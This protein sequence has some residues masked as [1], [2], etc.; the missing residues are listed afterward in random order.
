MTSTPQGSQHG[1]DAGGEVTPNDPQQTPTKCKSPDV[2]PEVSFKPE[3]KSK[4]DGKG[5]SGGKNADRTKP[6]TG[7]SAATRKSAEA[8]KQGAK[9]VEEEV[10][11]VTPVSAEVEAV[12][13]A[14]VPIEVMNLND[15][16]RKRRK[17]PDFICPSSED[18]SRESAVLD[19]LET[20]SI[21]WAMKTS[22]LL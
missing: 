2:K 8:A 22:P 1:D 14:E 15:L 12:K 6:E 3:V 18:K 5:K 7:K 9:A 19:W 16:K 4:T 13:L 11:A 10:K 21:H 17:L 20:T